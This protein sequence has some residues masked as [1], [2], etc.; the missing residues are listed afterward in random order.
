MIEPCQHA[1]QLR[2]GTAFCRLCGEW[3]PPS[4]VPVRAIVTL[5]AVLDDDARRLLFGDLAD[6]VDDDVRRELIGQLMVVL[7]NHGWLPMDPCPAC[8]AQR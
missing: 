4:L 3:G 8:G 2:L 1:W 7:E 5:E 6:Q